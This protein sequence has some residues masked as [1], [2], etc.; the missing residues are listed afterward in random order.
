M[1]DEFFSWQGQ[2]Q[3]IADLHNI[4]YQEAEQKLHNIEKSDFNFA[5]FLWD[6]R[7][8][9]DR[10]ICSALI[11]YI[12]RKD[13]DMSLNAENGM[14]VLMTAVL[15]NDVKLIEMFINKGIKIDSINLAEIM[16]YFSKTRRKQLFDWGL[17]GDDG[18]GLYE[19]IDYLLGRG[20]KLYS[21]DNN[22]FTPLIYAVLMEN[23]NLVELFLMKGMEINKVEDVQ[24]DDEI[25]FK[26]S[27]LFFAAFKVKSPDICEF[28]IKKGADINIEYDLFHRLSHE[29]ARL[30]NDDRGF[31]QVAIE[32]EKHSLIELVIQKHKENNIPFAKG[33]YISPLFKKELYSEEHGG[34][35][36]IVDKPID[37]ITDTIKSLKLLA[38]EGIKILQDGKEFAT[39]EAKKSISL[40]YDTTV[41]D[42]ITF[43]KKNQQ[44]FEKLDINKSII[45]MLDNLLEMGADINALNPLSEAIF[46]TKSKPLIEYL[47]QH[48]ADI[49]A[50]N[51]YHGKDRIN[52]LMEICSSQEL[53]RR[54]FDIV[55]L[56]V[57]NGADI[58]YCDNRGNTVLFKLIDTYSDQHQINQDQDEN[59]ELITE[60]FPLPEFPS[61]QILKFLTTKKHI[62]INVR[63]KMGFTPL[64]H[65]SFLGNERVVK[66]LLD[67]GADINVKSDATAL[68]LT[69]VD[70]IVKLIEEKRNNN[71][72]QLVSILKRFTK[73]DSNLKYTTH[74]WSCDMLKKY[75]SFD[76]YQKKLDTEWKQ[77]EKILEN[78]SEELHEVIKEYLYGAKNKKFSGWIKSKELAIESDKTK[79]PFSFTFDGESLKK[80]SS[81]FKDRIEFRGK[82]FKEILESSS[83][84]LGKKFNINLK[85]VPPEFQFYTDTSNFKC[86]LELIFKQIKEV[87]EKDKDVSKNID[88]ELELYENEEKDYCDLKIIHVDSFSAKTA[89]YM[90]ERIED[91]SGSFNI[92]TNCLKNLCDFSIQNIYNGKPYQVNF[93][94]S[95]NVNK[96]KFKIDSPK[97][98]TYLLRIYR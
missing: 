89:T 52:L 84:S 61:E 8:D 5:Q 26:I 90:E 41:K 48:G 72:Q 58:D 70:N 18:S 87:T 40:D 77:I 25:F 28:L 7:N 59:G 71:P 13:V 2:I 44:F 14:N 69:S 82:M 73:E 22:K 39:K 74:D 1:E 65:H 79:D 63:N 9:K 50:I 17:S 64:M 21:K 19:I 88:L 66:I 85:R 94:H 68:D 3:K 15:Y 91:N 6:I 60:T 93:L 20:I 46:K 51:F 78:L 56:L 54:K 67:Y 76:E 35:I 38:K 37:E 32:L 55:K 42:C 81:E 23:K 95:N 10:E 24:F 33:Y 80:I 27:P 97:G 86:A 34:L 92:M 12:L 29:G 96:K 36:P 31:L 30:D 75:G 83:R 16:E 49:N 62:N 11:Q 43:G 4:S 98:F 53:G 47:V 45:E 57:E